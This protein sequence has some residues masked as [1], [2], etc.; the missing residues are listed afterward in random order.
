MTDATP[1]PL[2]FSLRLTPCA[3]TNDWRITLYDAQTGTYL[4]F[5]SLAQLDAFLHIVTRSATGAD[6]PVAP[7]GD[8]R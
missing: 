6:P 5:A 8:E 2:A 3:G 1:T 4:R 7:S